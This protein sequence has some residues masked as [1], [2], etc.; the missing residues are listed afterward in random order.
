[1]KNADQELKE[2]F[3]Y[4]NGTL[5]NKL[6]I[7]QQSELMKV[8]YQTVSK[9]ITWLFSHYK[10]IQPIKSI[11][12]LAKIHKFLYVDLYDWAGEFRNYELT[13]DDTDF[14]LSH[15]FPEATNAIN[16]LIQDIQRD[17]KPS[18]SQ[19]AQLLDYL[20]Y[21]HPFREGNGRST[22]TFL[23]IMAA[24]KGQYLNYDRQDEQVIKALKDANVKQLEKFIRVE[25]LADK[26]KIMEL[27]AQRQIS[28]YEKRLLK[29]KCS[30]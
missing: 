18:V 13:K 30:R 2:R 5:R 28:D 20:N 12:D 6:G 4:S 11:G 3:Q 10:K 16:N 24:Q 21:L 22:K 7:R 8:E 29:D 9:K 15:S 23:V 1:M 26:N 14:M 25:T 27:A 17:S 19:Y